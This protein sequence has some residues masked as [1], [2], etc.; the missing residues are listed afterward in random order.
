MITEPFEHLYFN[1]LCAKIAYNLRQTPSLTYWDL[2]RTLHNTEYV[3][4]IVGDD[5]RAEDGLYLRRDFIYEAETPDDPDWRRHPPCS[6]LEMLVAFSKRAEFQS[7]EPAKAWFWEFIDNLGMK[8]F[9]DGY[10]PSSEEIWE[11]TDVFMWRTYDENGIGG[12]L[13]IKNGFRHDQREL[14]IWY[15]LPDYLWDTG[16]LP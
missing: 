12:I 7:S 14:E 6:L 15:Q 10:Q 2:L 8:E 13:P 1:W 5:N 4:F 3:W 9:H 11:I 16:R